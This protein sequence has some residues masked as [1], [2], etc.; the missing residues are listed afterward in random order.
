MAAVTKDSKKSKKGFDLKE[1]GRITLQHFQRAELGRQAAELA[2]Y[3]LLSLFP[4]LLALGNVIPLLPIP[5]D[6]VLEY[7]EM[8]VPAEVGS[9]LLPILEDYLS[10][11]S[12]GAITIGVII[13][14][15]TASKAFSVFQ[16]VLNQVYDSEVKRN[17]I[18]A[19]IFSF[20]IAILLVSLL[21]VVA[22]LF[23][24]GREILVLVQEFIPVDLVGVITTFEYFRW[25]V[26][27]VVLIGMMAVVYFIVPNVN[28]PF[29]YS[30]PGAILA[31]VGF[32]LISQ[33][34]SLYISFAGGQA[35]GNGTIGV[36]IVLMIWLYLLGNVFILGGVLNVVIYDYLHEDEA[37]INEE[38]TYLSVVYSEK[39]K[40]YVAR[41]QILR[42]SLLKDN[43]RIKMKDLPGQV[44]PEDWER[45]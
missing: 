28:W 27:F 32:L 29:K 13:S 39:G 36:F 40:D 15:W 11:G 45:P 22:F 26:A 35:I 2:Y 43:P 24:F 20:F 42:K 44:T 34:F 8:G 18:I 19:R 30:V 5:T 21:A 6:Q 9:I 25:I 1:I 31:T 37:V 14:L 12:G 33:L 16:R 10:G 23:V 7:V 4:V 17:F 41:Q 3:I 38:K